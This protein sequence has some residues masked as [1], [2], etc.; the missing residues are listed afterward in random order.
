M[1]SPPLALPGVL[2]VGEDE[3]ARLVAHTGPAAGWM[4][5]KGILS[6]SHEVSVVAREALTEAIRRETKIVMPDEQIPPAKHPLTLQAAQKSPL[7]AI[8]GRLTPKLVEMGVRVH[9]IGGDRVTS[10]FY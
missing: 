3:R 4:I 1:A 9:T 6:W 10:S 2:F 8:S 7:V 5:P